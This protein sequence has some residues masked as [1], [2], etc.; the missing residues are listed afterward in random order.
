M[1]TIILKFQVYRTIAKAAI[2]VLSFFGNN[3]R[4]SVL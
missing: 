1:K 4:K 3:V 2:D